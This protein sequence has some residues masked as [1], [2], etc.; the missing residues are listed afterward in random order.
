MFPSCWA[1]RKAKLHKN[2]TRKQPVTEGQSTPIS[3]CSLGRKR[4]L[5]LA[6]QRV[7]YCQ[8]GNGRSSNLSSNALPDY[9]HFEDIPTMQKIPVLQLSGRSTLHSKDKS[10]HQSDLQSRSSSF[11]IPGQNKPSD[12]FHTDPDILAKNVVSEMEQRLKGRHAK[13]KDS[14]MNASSKK[15]PKT[16]SP[17]QKMVQPNVIKLA[18]SHRYLL[19]LYSPLNLAGG[20][21]NQPPLMI[22]YGYNFNM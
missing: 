10:Y 15:M 12:I 14:V 20:T 18:T 9:T 11:L 16:S 17:I 3:C 8:V 19:D 6:R 21:G 13:L 5:Y 2:S 4:R 22:M 7:Q 1:V